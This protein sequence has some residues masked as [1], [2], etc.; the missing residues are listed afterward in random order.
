LIVVSD[1]SP[2]LNL[3][4]VGRSDLLCLLYGE[5]LAPGIV[6]EELRRNGVEPEILHCLSVR[7]PRDR[8]LIV[9]LQS[10]LDAGESAA[11]ALAL[12]A[13]A[14][15]LLAD[16]R[17]GRRKA[18]EMGLEVVGLLGVV[19]EAKRRGLIAECRP[20]LDALER[21][22]RFWISR[23]LRDRFLELVGEQASPEA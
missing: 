6:A 9:R 19:I 20:I 17:K 1:T 13:G 12:E 3:A 10:D 7:E 2:L 16:E 8:S 11:I 23:P 22:A 4:R 21:E 15:L 18:V 5:I 14:D